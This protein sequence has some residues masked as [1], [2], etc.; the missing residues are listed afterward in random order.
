M[1]V[2]KKSGK[3]NTTYYFN[4]RNLLEEYYRKFPEQM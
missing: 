2:E 4:I 1:E 3:E